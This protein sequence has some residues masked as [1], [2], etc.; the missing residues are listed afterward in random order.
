MIRSHHFLL[1]WT[2]PGE[3]LCDGKHCHQM[4]WFSP[5]SWIFLVCKPTKIYSDWFWS[6]LWVGT[7]EI[8]LHRAGTSGSL[9]YTL[10]SKGSDTLIGCCCVSWVWSHYRSQLWHIWP[11]ISQFGWKYENHG[12]SQVFVNF[13]MVFA[14]K[15]HTFFRGLMI[16]LLYSLVG[17]VP[18]LNLKGETKSLLIFM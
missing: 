13:P 3:F 17:L 8:K 6:F 2:W 9:F 4:Q 10:S 11:L 5:T 14:L 12:K 16:P 18:S 7:Q 15:N 1:M